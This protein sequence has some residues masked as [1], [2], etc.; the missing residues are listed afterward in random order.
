MIGSIGR[1]YN[2]ADTIVRK[3]CVRKKGE[4]GNDKRVEGG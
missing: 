1:K 3:V 4:C 2:W